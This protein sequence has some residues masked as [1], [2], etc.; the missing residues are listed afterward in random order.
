M[1]KVTQEE[2]REG[3]DGGGGWGGE[4]H[5]VTPPGCSPWPVPLSVIMAP[6]ILVMGHPGRCLHF[7]VSF[8]SYM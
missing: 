7:S 2:G 4:R 8:E 1:E 3:A 5:L 6:Q